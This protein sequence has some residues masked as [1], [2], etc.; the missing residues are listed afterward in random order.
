MTRAIILISLG[1]VVL[2]MIGLAL[3]IERLRHDDYDTVAPPPGSFA[4][5]YQ[6]TYPCVLRYLTCITFDANASMDLTVETFCQ[7]FEIRGRIWQRSAD[8]RLGWLWIMVRENL[9]R[10]QPG[11]P[12]DLSTMRRLGF[13]LPQPTSAE[14]HNVLALGSEII[15]HNNIYD[16][17]AGLSPLERSLVRMH[18]I[19]DVDAEVIATHLGFG[20]DFVQSRVGASLRRLADHG[21]LRPI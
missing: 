9:L 3:V 6:A 19:F 15:E 18:V 17:F 4:D 14:E 10:H 2:V 8:E 5:W 16:A 13:S 12:V 21:S 1:F 11:T 7:A 20:R